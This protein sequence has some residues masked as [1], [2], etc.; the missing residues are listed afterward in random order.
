MKISAL[1]YYIEKFF[2][3]IRVQGYVI[4]I[5]FQTSHRR[6]CMALVIRIGYEKRYK[7]KSILV[8]VIHCSYS[9]R[10]SAVN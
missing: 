7:S 2:V 8:G 10:L 4:M 3:F 6:G 9:Y 1:F 5:T